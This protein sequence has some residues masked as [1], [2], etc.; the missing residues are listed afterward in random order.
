MTKLRLRGV[1][2]LAKDSLANKR[3]ELRFKPNLDW[4]QSHEFSKPGYCQTQ[5][6]LDC[7]SEFFGSFF[8]F[9][10]YFYFIS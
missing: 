2:G 7:I 8:N 9:N 5:F 3:T 10:F 1:K 4:L 6:G